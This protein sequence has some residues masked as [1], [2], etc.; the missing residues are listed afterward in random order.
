[1]APPNLAGGVGIETRQREGAPEASPSSAGT[2]NMISLPRLALATPSAGSDPAPAS[3]AMMAAL[4]ARH[5]RVQHFRARARPVA[6]E[7][8]A[9]ITGF[10]GRHLDAWLMPPDVTREVFA[11]GSRQ[12]DLAIVEGTLDEA[13]VGPGQF[14]FDRPGR[15][16]PLVESLDLPMVAL[17][18]AGSLQGEH[19]PRLL[20]GVAAVVIDNLTDPD[21][22][23]SLRSMVQFIWKR[24]V[25][26][27]VEALPEARA[28]LRATP[29]DSPYPIEVID[30][31]AAS[32]LRFGDLNGI[33]ALADSRAFPI[34]VPDTHFGSGRLFR[35]AYAQDEAFGGYFP[36]T[37]EMLE[38]LGA[39]LVDFS[40]M[41]DESLPEAIDLVMIGCGFPDRHIDALTSNLSLITALR[42][43][44][45][46]GRR[47]YSE[48]GGTAYLGRSLILGDRQVPG[49][50][51]LPFDAELRSDPQSPA[52]VSRTLTQDGWLGPRGTVVRGYRSGRWRLRPAPEPDDCPARSGVLTAHRDIYFRNRAVGSLIHLHLSALPDVVSAFA[53]APRPVLSFRA[54]RD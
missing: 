40:P 30:R 46:R 32:F 42:A 11:R 1:M 43:H 14:P 19:L 4:T 5:C 21:A 18:D 52:P 31:L 7:T 10:P 9:P 12:A 48:G 34:A 33:R 15:L 44:V 28:A 27:A 26:G 47:I 41:R 25:L 2:L 16:A 8:L 20:P 35:V 54:S 29:L 36:D 24:P 51:I 13:D 45:C 6:F 37:L 53:D 49:A 17:V 50:G 38:M 3:L 23:S 39:E 22:F